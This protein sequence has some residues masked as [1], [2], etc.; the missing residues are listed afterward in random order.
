MTVTIPDTEV[1]RIRSEH[2]GDDFE[3]WVARPQAGFVPA[4]GRPSVLY[5]LDANLFFGTVVE[6]TRIMHRLYGELP[7]L[8]V[9]GIAYPGTD[10]ARQGALRARDFTPSEDRGMAEMAAEVPT[11]PGAEPVGPIVPPMGGAGAFRRFLLAEV[12]PIIEERF[13]V[14]DRNRTIFGSSMGG[15]FVTWTVLHHPESF[16]RYLAVSPALWWNEAELLQAEAPTDLPGV[17]FAVGGNEEAPEVPM[18]A[19]YRMISNARALATRLGAPIE[20]LEGESHTSVVP[21]A[22]SRGLRHLFPHRRPGV[23]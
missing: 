7:Q 4:E 5:V 2:V 14:S 23:G 19:R 1:H 11:M 9:V 13:D 22:L 3:V 12:E 10:W 21:V 8:L 16:E 18:L 15:L 17:Y 20:V 6:M